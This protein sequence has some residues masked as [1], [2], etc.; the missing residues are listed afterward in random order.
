MKRIYILP[1][2][3]AVRFTSEGITAASKIEYSG[4]PADPN[5]EILTHRQNS[6]WEEDSDE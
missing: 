3:I 2:T 4:D 6:I 5:A 1:V